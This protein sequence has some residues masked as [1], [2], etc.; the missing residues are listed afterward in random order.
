MTFIYFLM[1]GPYLLV[2]EPQIDVIYRNVMRISLGIETTHYNISEWPLVFVVQLCLII[3][4]L[5]HIPF[6]YY[7]G[8]EN[9]LMA[10]DEFYSSNLSNMVMRVKK[11]DGDPRFF[12]AELKDNSRKKIIEGEGNKVVVL[13]RLPHMRMKKET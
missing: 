7:I 8:K 11:E 1:I 9:F 6:I 12:L 5:M 10:Y 3:Q 4:L 2:L 13:H